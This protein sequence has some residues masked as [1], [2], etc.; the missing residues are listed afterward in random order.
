MKYWFKKGR[1]VYNNGISKKGLK[2]DD[3]LEENDT[4]NLLYQKAQVLG[5]N[6]IAQ[7][8]HDAEFVNYKKKLNVKKC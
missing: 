6:N 8:I 2:I 4:Y 3:S 1:R 7:A 5:Y